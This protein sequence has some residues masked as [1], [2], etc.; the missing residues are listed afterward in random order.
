MFIAMHIAVLFTLAIEVSSLTQP[1]D[2]GD[3]KQLFIDGRFIAESENVKLHVNPPVK[4]GIVLRGDKPWDE[5]WI[6]YCSVLDDGSGEYK[7]YYGGYAIGKNGKL[8][9]GGL[10]LATSPDGINW[11]KPDLGV[12]DFRGSKA[13]NLVGTGAEFCVFLDPKASP[14]QRY[15]MLRVEGWDDPEKGGLYIAYSADGIHWTRHPERLLPLVPDT[16]NQV[17]YDTRLGKYVAY[18]R[19]WAPMRKVAR[20]EIDDLLAPWPYDKSVKPYLIWGEKHPPVPSYEFPH[21]ISYDELDPPQTD[22]YTP[23]VVQYPWAEDVYLAFPSMYYHFP[24]PPKGKYHND[25]L[26]E[27]Q[28]GVS[29]DG[30]RFERPDRRAYVPLGP[31]GSSDGGAMYMA[32]G[33]IR[34]GDEIYQYYSGFRCSHG[35]Y[36]GFEELR[37]ISH[38]HLLVQRLDGFVSADGAYSGG[39]LTTPPLIFSGRELELNIDCGAVGDAR[40]ELRTENNVPIEGYTAQECDLI[41]GNLVHCRVTW[42][43]KSDLSSLAGKTVRL[44]FL[45]RNARLYGFQFHH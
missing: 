25:G 8:G 32:P 5:G 30:V 1:I 6:G 14:E 7:L 19:C 17:F 44:H 15:K 37:G 18:L 33:M 27:I 36:V 43:G 20:A 3:R 11:E 34:R 22:V 26:L 42:Q 39:W 24:E 31:L 16:Q 40:V 41:R 13:N 2:V 9:P 23:C 10:C 28:L 45:L 35:E 4:R 21:A 12:V 29:R 38:V